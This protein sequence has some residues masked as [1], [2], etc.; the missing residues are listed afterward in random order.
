MSQLVT[1]A[2]GKQENSAGFSHPAENPRTR[3]LYIDNIRWTMIILVISMHAADTYSLFR[4]WYF[5]DRRPLSP[6]TIL[7]FGAW[8]MYVQ[9]FFM[10][11][12]FF[13]AGF[14]VPSSFE[15]K[16]AL[17][18]LRDRTIRLGIPVL[19]YMFAIGPA[20]EYYVAHSWT[21][22]RPTSFANE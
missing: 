13:I 7:V 18:F 16:G 17:G 19:L 1:T 9:A 6:A 4:N 8:Q 10:G 3:L 22:T 15:R 21:S 14:F 20:T 12:L 2:D 11:L 5:V